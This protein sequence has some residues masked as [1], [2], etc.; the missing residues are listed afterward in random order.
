[1][2]RSTTIYIF[3]LALLAGLYY[4]LN[5]RPETVDAEPTAEPIAQIEYLFSPTDG[6]P[7]QI[8]IESKTG[9]VV[10]VVRDKENAWALIQPE[11][12]AADQGTVEAAASQVT[13]MQILERI[14]DLL[15]ETVG[16]NEPEY[17][18]SMQ[19][20]SGMERNM[21][22]GVLTPTERGYYMRGEDGSIMIIG[23]ST[24]D[25]LLGLLSNPPYAPTEAP[26]SATP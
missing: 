8:L 3:V 9:E 12:A 17:I 1:M 2:R 20:T 22:I 18:I 14:P 5:N 13:T 25:S 10:E 24:V 16:L 21:E 26:A 11:E 23:R 7:T 6:L 19:F 15:P 4:F